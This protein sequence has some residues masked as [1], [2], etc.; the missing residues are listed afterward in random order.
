MKKL[1]RK[2]FSIAVKKGTDANKSKFAKEAV[3]GEMYYAT[4]TGSLYVANNNNWTP[5]NGTNTFAWWDAN[6][7]STI[8]ENS[9]SE[10]TGW[11]DKISSKVLTPV[12]STTFAGTVSA[13]VLNSKDVI[14]LSADDHFVHEDLATHANY[15]GDLGVYIVAKV[16]VVDHGSDSV[17]SINCNTGATGAGADFQLD[18][19]HTSKFQARLVV[20][21]ATGTNTT[22]ASSNSTDKT[23][24]YHIFEA[25]FDKSGT[26]KFY[27]YV[28]GTPYT[29]YSNGSSYTNNVGFGSG[30]DL[31][32]FT[33]RGVNRWPEG[34]VAEIICMADVG[35]REKVEG[36]L[37]HK[38]GLAANLPSNHTYKSSAP[39]IGSV[40][41]KYQGL[42]D[43][44]Y[45]LS[46]DG[47]DD[48]MGSL[49]IDRLGG[50][51]W[52]TTTPVSQS[53]WVKAN[54][55]VV[56]DGIFGI[57]QHNTD[58]S[59]N[60]SFAGGN[61]GIHQQESGG[62]MRYYLW[63]SATQHYLTGTFSLGVWYHIAWTWDGTNGVIYV[64][65]VQNTTFTDTSNGYSTRF[66]IW[67]GGR[68]RWS[69]YG[70]CLIDELATWDSAL[71]AA[72]ISTIYNS[73][74]PGDITS[75]SPLVWYR[76]GDGTEAGSGTDIYD[77][78][79]NSSANAKLFN[80]ATYSTDVPT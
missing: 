48:Y 47:S 56:N 32:V 69:G 15:N 41:T 59:F 70:D 34:Q 53:A 1:H 52:S 46:F 39:I 26:A 50:A 76:M 49:P 13:G 14:D 27:S 3:L 36:Y 54:S 65:G 29:N 30:A 43:N 2:D 5:T 25:I 55:N 51:T 45:S 17:I 79:G 64:D 7:S 38:W 80:G 57:G 58:G 6:D 4:D 10:I 66:S 42:L 31:N 67:A 16:D 78:S 77:M 74:V 62:Q 11:R 35:D 68:G 75:L 12:S 21:N 37:A 24:A 19:S 63:L 60:A 28:D 73:G 22:T 8:T 44:N 61:G 18:A 9:L 33:N 71:T 20:S 40:L 72:N 23:G